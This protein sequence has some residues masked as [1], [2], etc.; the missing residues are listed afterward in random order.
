MIAT[1]A[2]SPPGQLAPAPS[3]PQNI[4]KELSITP[5]ASFIVF[6]G[7]LARGALAASPATLT[8]K[9]G[10]AG[11]RGRECEVML[12]GAEREHDECDLEPLEQH[13]FEGDGEGVAVEAGV[14]A[15]D[16]ARRLGLLG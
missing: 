8:T 4:P 1:S 12:V 14:S 5:T 10:R 6:S 7:T 16:R 13:S 15:P 3:A 11:G 9:H 2:A